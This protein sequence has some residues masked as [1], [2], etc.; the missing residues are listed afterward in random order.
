[1]E[2][3]G[4]KERGDKTV[5]EYTP[6]HTFT[7]TAMSTS[8][9]RHYILFTHQQMHFLNLEKFKFTWKYT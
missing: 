7:V 9:L 8:N 1:M 4:H 2:A 5:P 3:E 6:L